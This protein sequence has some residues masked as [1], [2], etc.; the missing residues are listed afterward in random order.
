MLRH[1]SYDDRRDW[2]A[3]IAVY[4]P[5]ME[6]GQNGRP[7]PDSDVLQIDGTGLHSGY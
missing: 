2:L 5:F 4:Q 3:V 7:G 6:W 1:A